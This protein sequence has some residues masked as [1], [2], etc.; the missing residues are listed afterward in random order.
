MTKWVKRT[1]LARAGF[2]QDIKRPR[3]KTSEKILNPLGMNMT[4]P[5]FK[6]PKFKGF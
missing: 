2:A 6:M 5:K 4:L 3:K 1:V